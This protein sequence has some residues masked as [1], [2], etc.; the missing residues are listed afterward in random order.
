VIGRAGDNRPVSQEAA[1]SGGR[2]GDQAGLPDRKLLAQ[3][4][5]DVEELIAQHSWDNPPRRRMAFLLGEAIELAEEVLQW[6]ESGQAD[7]VLRQRLGQEMYDVLWNT[8]AL[9]RST[10]I[11]LVAAADGKRRFNA[12][13]TWP[14]G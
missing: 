1:G 13:R 12:S 7:P 10:G 11:D 6:P 4:M 2:S 3:I 8:C 5:S 14:G 9:A